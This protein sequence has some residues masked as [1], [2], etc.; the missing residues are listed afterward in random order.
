M[1]KDI[2]LYCQESESIRINVFDIELQGLFI[3]WCYGY[4]L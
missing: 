1:I 2:K 3:S 4:V